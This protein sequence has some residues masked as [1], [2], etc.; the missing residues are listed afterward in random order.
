MCG[1]EHE[2]A[3]ARKKLEMSAWNWSCRVVVCLIWMLRIEL[4]PSGRA[5]LGLN[6]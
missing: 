3:G 2:S 1:Y 4:R 6:C 5:I